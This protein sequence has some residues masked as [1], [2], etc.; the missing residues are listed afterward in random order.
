[1]EN[2]RHVPAY[3]IGGTRDTAV[4]IEGAR[5][6]TE[7]LG[8][9]HYDVTFREFPQYGH[10]AFVTDL[11][12]V[13]DWLDRRR[14]VTDPAIVEFHT[15]SPA[16][17]GA[18]WVSV[19]QLVDY[20]KPGTCRAEM[21]TQNRLVVQTDNVAQVTLSPSQRLYDPNRP[22]QFTINGQRILSERIPAGRSLTLY[23]LLAGG[24]QTGWSLRDPEPDGLRKSPAL[25]GPIRQA[26]DSPHLL[27]YGTAGTDEEIAANLAAAHAAADY[28][29]TRFTHLQV[30][31]DKDVTEED[32]THRHLVL[33]G[34]Q[35]SNSLLEKMSGQLPIRIVGNA[36]VL[37]DKRFQGEDVGYRLVFPN[38]LRP[39]R[40]V[41]V[42]AGLS[43]AALKD[44]GKISRD[45]DYAIFDARAKEKQEDGKPQPLLAS[46]FFDRHWQLQ[47]RSE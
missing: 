37:G 27:V 47:A 26:T 5:E 34:S 21:L 46:G 19:G 40:L 38:P 9:L 24:R 44:I 12:D 1:V 41:V 20:A 15:V 16:C 2:L 28:G 36:V 6:M 32:L 17:S 18:Y 43:P 35:H 45:W 22:V 7:T 3:I 33:F 11:D 25:C 39:D 29:P 30:K 42:N 14:R 13:F 4:K 8:K 10:G 31:A 23:A